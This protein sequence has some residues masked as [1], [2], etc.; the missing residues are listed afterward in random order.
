[1]SLES[2]LRGSGDIGAMLSN[3]YGVRKLDEDRNLVHVECHNAR[4]LDEQ[5]KP[6]QIEGRS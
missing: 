6:F 3:A 5:V 1:M 4:D 2:V